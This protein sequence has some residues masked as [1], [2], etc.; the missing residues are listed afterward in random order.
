MQSTAVALKQLIFKEHS[1]SFL[2]FLKMQ[3]EVLIVSWHNF[4]AF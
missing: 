3:F 1:I 4:S 2:F